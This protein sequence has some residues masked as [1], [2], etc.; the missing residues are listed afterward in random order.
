M[1]NVWRKGPK[2][3]SLTNLNHIKKKMLNDVF[4]Y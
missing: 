3:I 1:V 2:S 4:E